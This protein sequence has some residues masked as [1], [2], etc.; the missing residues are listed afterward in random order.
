VGPWR[1]RRSEDDLSGN[2][3]ADPGAE[4]AVE[5]VAGRGSAAESEQCCS[6]SPSSAS[7]AERTAPGSVAAASAAADQYPGCSAPAGQ[8]RNRCAGVHHLIATNEIYEKKI[9]CSCI[10]EIPSRYGREK[11]I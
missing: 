11:R 7:G 8:N 1:E 2:P 10:N 3:H 9:L 5:A 4:A 6:G